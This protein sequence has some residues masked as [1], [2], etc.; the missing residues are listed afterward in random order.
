M[1]EEREIWK[2]IGQNIKNIIKIG[3]RILFVK[4]FWISVGSTIFFLL[5]IPAIKSGDLTIWLAII[6]SLIGG[7]LGHYLSPKK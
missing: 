7:I 2:D 6:G 3:L 1:E 5:M 4:Y